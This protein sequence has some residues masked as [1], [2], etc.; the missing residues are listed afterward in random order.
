MDLSHDPACD[1]SI[2][3]LT[4]TS[5]L[6]LSGK[7][8]MFAGE[9]SRWLTSAE[10][11]RSISYHRGKCCFSSNAPHV[12]LDDLA[13]ITTVRSSGLVRK[14]GFPRDGLSQL[15]RS[16][17]I[18]KVILPETAIQ[19]SF[20]RLCPTAHTRASE[21]PSHRPQSLERDKTMKGFESFEL[22]ITPS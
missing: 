4:E 19:D 18:I 15:Q 14:A 17:C 20:L 22:V 1:S 10:Q 12:F 11:L 13:Y 16:A 7:Y 9:I 8:G 6:Y 3:F 5:R 2:N 21:L